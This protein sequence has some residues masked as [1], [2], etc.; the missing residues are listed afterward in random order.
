MSPMIRAYGKGGAG[1]A[2]K[3]NETVARVQ[4]AQRR[5]REPRAR[6]KLC[7]GGIKQLG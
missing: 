1:S 2:E 5:Q 3:V 4:P 7:A 6:A